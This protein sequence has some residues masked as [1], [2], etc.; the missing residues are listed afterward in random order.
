MNAIISLSG[1]LFCI[2][3]LFRKINE[4]LVQRN[5]MIFGGL[6]ISVL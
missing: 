4:H 5:K 3:L 2:Y 1:D 6:L